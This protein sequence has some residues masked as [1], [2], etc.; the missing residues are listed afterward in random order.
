[1]YLGMSLKSDSTHTLSVGLVGGPIGAYLLTR[2]YRDSSIGSAFQAIPHEKG[3]H[4]VKIARWMLC[5]LTL[6]AVIVGCGEDP[7]ELFTLADV[8][9][10]LKRAQG[11]WWIVV[12]INGK[13]QAHH[14]HWL[15]LNRTGLF[16]H[17]V[18]FYNNE[19]SRYAPS[20]AAQI[21]YTT[22]GRYTTQGNILTITKA[23][24]AWNVEVSLWPE[25]AWQEKIEGMT[26]EALESDFATAIEKGFQRF[27]L[28]TLLLFKDGTEYTWRVDGGRLTLSSSHQ[29]IVLARDSPLAELTLD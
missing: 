16:R 13:E 12:S 6:S 21:S 19:G 28:E 10:H 18:R 5:I 25:A 24:T 23:S 8:D 14:S 11:D 9:D 20:M 1:M 3:E 7:N 17:D 29:T 2:L 4:P 27:Q 22:R 15:T 26:I